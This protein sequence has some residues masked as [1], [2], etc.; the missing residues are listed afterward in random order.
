MIEHWLTLVY[1]LAAV[2]VLAF[3]WVGGLWLMLWIF[4]KIA[5]RREKQKDRS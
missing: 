3:F 2:L 5:T 4:E 1:D